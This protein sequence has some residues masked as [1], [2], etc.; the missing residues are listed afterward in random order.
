[1]FFLIFSS[2]VSGPLVTHVPE[3][4]TRESQMLFPYGDFTH[5]VRLSMNGGKTFSFQGVVEVTPYRI[6][7]VAL[8]P[9]QT[10][11]MR[12]MEDRKTGEVK[13]DCYV[14]EVSRYQEKLNDYYLLVRQILLLERSPEDAAGVRRLRIAGGADV[15]LSSYEVGIPRRIDVHDPRFQLEIVVSVAREEAK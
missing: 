3:K 11:L 7:L 2:C 12:V 1:M 6:Q 4:S 8:S 9:F 5:D 10:T 14:A 13:L 15:T